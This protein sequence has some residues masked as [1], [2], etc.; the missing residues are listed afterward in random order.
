MKKLI[1][2]IIAILFAACAESDQQRQE[3]IAAQTLSAARSALQSANY[4]QARDSI[5]SLRRNTPLAFEAR[6]QAILL[7]DSIELLAARDSLDALPPSVRQMHIS[8]PTTQDAIDIAKGNLPLVDE[9]ERLLVK[10]QFYERKLHED[11]GHA[12]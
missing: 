12:K 3:R 9:Y 4:D 8:S 10:V 11:Q 5:I 2:V 1:P 6:R 7:L